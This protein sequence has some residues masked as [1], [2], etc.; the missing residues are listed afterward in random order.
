MPD[1][2]ANPPS[3]AGRRTEY[4]YD[5]EGRRVSVTDLGPVSGAGREAGGTGPGSD[6]PGP[7]PPDEPHVTGG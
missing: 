5:G 3:P 6:G 4:V 7:E 2:T 1:P